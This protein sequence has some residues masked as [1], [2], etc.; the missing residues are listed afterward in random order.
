MSEKFGFLVSRGN[1]VAI[2]GKHSHVINANVVYA[3]WVVGPALD[4]Q[5]QSDAVKS[6]VDTHPLRI[7]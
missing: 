7:V 1:H 4:A 6:H 5:L 2:T 3:F